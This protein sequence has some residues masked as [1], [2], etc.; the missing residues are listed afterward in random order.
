MPVCY[1]SRCRFLGL[2]GL[3]KSFT[4]D[5]CL[6]SVFQRVYWVRI[7]FFT[8]MLG[9]CVHRVMLASVGDLGKGTQERVNVKDPQEVEQ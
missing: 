7:A 1:R 4:L 9:F 6:L 3:D 8:I 5:F 2:T